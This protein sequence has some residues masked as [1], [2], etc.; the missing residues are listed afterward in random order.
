[1]AS[2]CMQTTRGL[3]R[4]HLPKRMDTCT[5]CG[6]EHQPVHETRQRRWRHLNFSQF[7]ANIHAKG[8]QLCCSPCPTATQAP[9]AWARPTS[10]FVQPMAVPAAAPTTDRARELR[11]VAGKGGAGGHGW[12]MFTALSCICGVS[13]LNL[14]CAFW[15]VTADLGL[16]DLENRSPGSPRQ[17]RSSPPA[18]GGTPDGGVSCRSCAGIRRPGG[19]CAPGA[20]WSRRRYR[21]TST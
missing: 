12:G 9:V 7:Q 10:G 14:R 1:M 3:I 18:L 8:V 6:A 4:K 17:I 5:H 13:T 11:G 15:I 20:G 21:G 19:R 16:F 2:K